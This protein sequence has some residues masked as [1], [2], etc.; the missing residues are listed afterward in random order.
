MGNF[1]SKIFGFGKDFILK[2]EATV[3]FIGWA[4]LFLVILCQLFWSI[5]LSVRQIQTSI[6]LPDASSIIYAIVYTIITILILLLSWHGFDKCI[7]W[8]NKSLFEWYE[9][10][11]KDQDYEKINI[12]TTN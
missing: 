4:I 1:I 12:D 5:P 7:E 10:E 6:N 8:W 9:N 3:W 11:K 2:S